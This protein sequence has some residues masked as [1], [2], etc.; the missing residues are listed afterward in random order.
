MSTTKLLAKYSIHPTLLF[1]L[2]II[3]FHLHGNTVEDKSYDFIKKF[4]DFPENNSQ[5]DCETISLGIQNDHQEALVQME[6]SRAVVVFTELDHAIYLDP[7]VKIDYLAQ[8]LRKTLNDNGAAFNCYFGAY[9]YN[10]RFTPYLQFIN[11]TDN[12]IYLKYFYHQVQ[13]VLTLSIDSESNLELQ[14][15]SIVAPNN[16][17][18]KMYSKFTLDMNSDELNFLDV[19]NLIGAEG[20]EALEYIKSQVKIFS[21][22]P[23]FLEGVGISE[24]TQ[25]LISDVHLQLK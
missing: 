24:E 9:T 25:E 16:K 17:E 22:L 10:M 21:S 19:T 8:L 18:V 14:N 1:A 13:F 2:L 3:L 12:S 23:K 15:I 5:S 4:L 20:Q 7:K 6:N 11:L